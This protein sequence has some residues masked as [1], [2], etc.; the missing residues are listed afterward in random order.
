MHQRSL[1]SIQSTDPARRYSPLHLTAGHGSLSAGRIINNGC[2][3]AQAPRPLSLP[4]TSSKHA[5]LGLTKSTALDGR[6][7]G[8][9]CTQLD[10]G[11]VAAGLTR[12]ALQADGTRVP[13]ACMKASDVAKSVVHIAE[14]PDEI[15]VLQMTIL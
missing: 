2:I 6:R 1:Q 9:T 10:V 15:M 5:I 11:P 8:I 3:S 12:I 14:L 4:F 7:Y 13:E